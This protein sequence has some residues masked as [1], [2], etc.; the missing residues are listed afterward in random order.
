VGSHGASEIYAEIL[1]DEIVRIRP[2]QSTD[3]S[4][5]TDTNRTIPGHVREIYPQ[6]VE[7]PSPLGVLQRRV[8]ILITLDENGPLK[9]G[10]E[11]N[12]HIRIADRKNILLAPRE[13]ISVDKDGV[14][15]V[16]T[17]RPERAGVYAITVQKIST[18]LKNQFYAEVLQGLKEGDILLR[19]G[20]LPFKNGAWIRFAEEP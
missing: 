14:E 8:P 15:I 16:R 6:A 19:D 13:S 7:K 10:Y 2:G 1:S 18:G 17:I 4:F 3:I 5:G 9:P 20:S 12:V 11:V